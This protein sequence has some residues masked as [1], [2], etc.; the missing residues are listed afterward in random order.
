VKSHWYAKIF[1]WAQFGLM[2][3]GQFSQGGI[4]RNWREW[5]TLIA[6]GAVAVATHA[7]SNTD[8]TK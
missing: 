4:P 2:T 1:G 5:T 7:A 6:S 8:G 3:I